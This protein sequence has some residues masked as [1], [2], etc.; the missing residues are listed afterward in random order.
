MMLHAGV[1]LAPHDLLRAWSFEP[2][3]AI[4]IALAG[5]LYV[6][7]LN[8]ELRRATRARDRIRFGAAMF[9]TG[10]IVLVIA[11]ISPVHRL[12]ESL[13]SAHMVQHELLMTVA[14]PLLVLAR[15]VV[16]FLWS[17]PIGVRRTLG[18]VFTRGKFQA[19]WRIISLPSLA[20]VIHGAAIWAWH[21]PPLYNAALRSEW[22]HALQHVSFFGTALLFWWALIHGRTRRTGYGL[23]II[24]VFFTA[25]HTTILGA[26]LALSEISWYSVYSSSL[27]VPW[28]LSPLEDQQLGGL[29]MWV[30]ATVAYLVAAL[31]LFVSWLRQSDLRVLAREN[32]VRAAVL[33]IVIATF[34]CSG[35]DSARAASLMVGGDG[36]R[37]AA[38]IRKYGC[39]SCHAIPGIREAAARVGPPLAGIAG[40][41]YIGGVISN[42][43]DHM[44]QWIEN[45][46]A[47][48]NK[49]AMPNM[50]VTE[51]DARDIATYLYTLK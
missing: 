43:P 15:P 3:V 50:G 30:P 21:A 7:G 18:D 28:G 5:G 42:T 29:I 13:F 31:A 11:L 51:R 24:L 19:I 36:D 16:P 37:G 47:I 4:P 23:S 48:D 12:G 34:G 35:P 10:W 6:K 38:A 9:G 44:I 14:A 49:S 8:T 20:T 33:L 1:P 27:T 41:S 26:L 22:M 2:G 40:R 17:V 32:V 45:P 46:Q 25:V 39:G